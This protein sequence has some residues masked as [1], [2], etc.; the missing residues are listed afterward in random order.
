[1][2][3]LVSLLLALLLVLSMGSQ[4]LALTFKGELG[5]PSTFETLAEAHA[6]APGFVSDISTNSGSFVP[7]PVLDDFPADT[8]WVYRSANMYGGRAAARMNT[9]LIVFSDQ[10]FEEKDSALAYLKELGLVDIIDQAI[11]S[12][13]LVTPINAEKGFTRDDQK[14]YYYIL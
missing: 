2:K 1:M 8:A 7:H 14:S 12:V 3:K 4:A 5:N 9:N 10:H 6:S 13:V 11:G